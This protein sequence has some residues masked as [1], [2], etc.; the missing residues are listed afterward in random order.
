MSLIKLRTIP[1][2]ILKLVSSFVPDRFIKEWLE[3]SRII[4]ETL[5]RKLPPEHVLA[6]DMFDSKYNCGFSKF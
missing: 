6:E 1:V 4:L 2:T 3:F 5:T